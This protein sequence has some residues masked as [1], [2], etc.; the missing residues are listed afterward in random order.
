MN[1]R[2]FIKLSG[3]AVG[4]AALLPA[5]TA[6]AAE[7]R[8]RLTYKAK[9]VAD[10][11]SLKTGQSVNFNYLDDSSPCLL[12]R[13]GKAVPGGVGPQQDIVAFSVLRTHQGCPMALVE[14]N[15]DDAA[16]LKRLRMA[17]LLKFTMTTVQPS[18]WPTLS[19]ISSP[20][21]SSRCSGAITA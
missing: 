1:R 17:I 4:A 12:L 11:K 7:N 15:P 9:E 21:R 16:E 19:R 6:A 10:E 14:I 8:A 5:A 3:T 13:T 2:N 18:P 20:T